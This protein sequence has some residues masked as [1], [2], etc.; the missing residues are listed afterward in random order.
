[1]PEQVDV[2]AETSTSD[3]LSNSPDAIAER[4]ASPAESSPETEQPETVADTPAEGEKPV[5]SEAA[6]GDAEVKPGQAIPY[7]RFKQVNEK[8]KLTAKELEEVRQSAEQFDTVLKDPDVFKLIR[9]KQGY[10]DEAISA[11]LKELGVEAA[12]AQ[13]EKPQYDLSTT[14]GWDKKIDDM[15]EQRLNTRLQP[16]QQTLTLKEQQEKQRAL[17]ESLAKQ[18][19]E[20]VKVSKD[21]Y[22]I[23]YGDEKNAIDPNTGAGKLALYMQ[24]Y[25]QT[26]ALI[27]S[28]QLT[29]TQVLHLALAEQGVK[30]GERKGVQAEKDRQGK[31]KAAA[32]ETDAGLS[33]EESP[34]SDWPTDRIL[35][36][37]AKHPNA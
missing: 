33:G 37:K 34:Q 18:T 35:A 29:K 7:D 23:E 16:I 22:G 25:P 1:M 32:M 21:V 15:I 30:I 2:T 12:E 5:E 11:E 26:P 14:E 10:T 36:W 8:L 19:E 6:E 13:K 3:I 31:L 9:K 4:E 24:K 28:G 17:D 20:V 27:K